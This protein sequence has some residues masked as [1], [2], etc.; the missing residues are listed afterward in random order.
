LS[1]R[2]IA[3]NNLNDNARGLIQRGALRFFASELAPTVF[4]AQHR[5]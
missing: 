5:R 4:N 3:V 2:R 1:G